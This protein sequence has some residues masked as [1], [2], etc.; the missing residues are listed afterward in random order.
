MTATTFIGHFL[1]PNTHASRPAVTGLPEG[2]MYVCTT[3]NKI[4]RVVSAAW[5]D[6]ATLGSGLTVSTD[7]IWDTK[8]D[9]AAAS[10]PD[11]ASKLPVGSNGQVLTADSTQTLGV[12]WA[13]AAAGAATDT[14]YDAKGDIVAASA[15]DTAARLP[16]G[17]NGQVLQADSTQTLGVKWATPATAPGVAADTIWDT[18]G[19]LA[20]ASGADTAAKLPVGTNGQVLTADSTQTTGVK[21]AAA[22][23][24][25]SVDVQAFT[26][27][28]PTN[29]TKPAG[30]TLVEVVLYGA[31]G[32]GG[33]GSSAGGAPMSGPTGGGGG[34]CTIQL[35]RASDL[36]STVAVTCGTGGAGGVGAFSANNG[37]AGGTST[38]GSNAA[39]AGGGGGSGG[40][41]GS[42]A[43][44]GSGGGRNTPGGTGSSAA[45]SGGGNPI[46]A[47]AAGIGGAGGGASPSS[48][49]TDAEYGG[50]AGG[51]SL[52]GSGVFAGGNSVFG[53]AGGGS[54]GGVT[55]GAA[56]QAGA[57]GGKAGNQPSFTGVAGTG[58]TGGTSGG[59]TGGTGTDGTSLNGGGGGGGAG[60]KTA[61]GGAAGG[62]GGAGGGGGGGGGNSSGA[63]AGT[64][65]KGGDGRV[66]VYA[67]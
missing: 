24:G 25:G 48:A 18:K 1:G 32:G 64:G 35:F 50:A 30:C 10:G 9:L 19:D 17:T 21:W 42:G 46:A 61:S 6:Y 4:E 51:G 60:S 34:A 27:T 26:S 5:V 57:A 40:N 63:T 12:K 8:G 66:Y 65:G 7:G 31:G 44:G 33:G 37:S 43:S 56:A 20:V 2:T 41:L 13:A 52:N 36:P 49:G 47:G 16:V 22:A 55:S 54:G 14:I 29:W 15:A 28:S 38:F 23:A 11:A 62:A 59:G 67:W 58:G 45:V 3:H 53:G 39:A